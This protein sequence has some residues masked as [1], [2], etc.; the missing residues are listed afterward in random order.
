MIKVTR[1][2]IMPVKQKEGLVGFA[3][4]VIN[5]DLLLGSIAIRRDRQGR[6]F[7]LYPIKK[8]GDKTFEIYHP[9]NKETSI[10]ISEAVVKRAKEV[11]IIEGEDN[12]SNEEEDE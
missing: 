11:I 9:L 1:V 7:I 10:A 3:T 4:V 12:K 2:D 6:Y 5:G 8:L